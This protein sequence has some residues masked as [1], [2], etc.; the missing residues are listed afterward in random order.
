MEREKFEVAVTDAEDIAAVIKDMSSRRTNPDIN[1]C[2]ERAAEIHADVILKGTKVDGVYDKDPALHADAIRYTSIEHLDILQQSLRVMDATAASL[3]MD[4]QIPVIV[5][6]LN[7]EG[8]ILR[9]MKGEVLGTII[10]TSKD[11]QPSA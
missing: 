4:N 2:T 9:L 8:S 11:N 7:N 10:Q 5:F 3:C 6:N 1:F